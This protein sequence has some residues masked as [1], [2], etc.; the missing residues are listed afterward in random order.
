VDDLVVRFRHDGEGA[1]GHYASLLD[2]RNVSR[3]R[4]S[5]SGYPLRITLSEPGHRPVTAR[6]GGIFDGPL[7]PSKPM[8]P[9]GVTTLMIE[10]NSHCDAR[11]TGRAG[12][13]YH[14]VTV[15]LRA[16]AISTSTRH[17]R[18]LSVGCGAFASKFGRWL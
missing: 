16:G 10:T 3:T 7:L 4:C 15:A 2:F 14:R 12:P 18:R 13:F 17:T 8:V 1:T 6:R 9:G 5:L 11:P